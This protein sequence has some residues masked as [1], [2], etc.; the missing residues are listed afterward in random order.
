MT[1]PR[2]V[3]VEDTDMDVTEYFTQGFRQALDKNY[4]KRTVDDR[5][6]SALLTRKASRVTLMFGKRNLPS[7]M[8]PF[9]PYKKPE[10]KTPQQPKSN[11]K[12]EKYDRLKQW[13]AN[14]ERLK[15]LQNKQSRPIFKV[16]HVET[17]I[18][19]PDLTLV[20]S[21]IKG[22]PI[23]K[24]HN[25]FVAPSRYKVP[26][27]MGK[28]KAP[29]PTSKPSNSKIVQSNPPTNKTKKPTNAKI[30]PVTRMA[31]RAS[32]KSTVG[33]PQKAS[34]T[35]STN[36][37][38]K[39]P[40]TAQKKP[41]NSKKTTVKKE[42]PA[43]IKEEVIEENT[44]EQKNKKSVGWGVTPPNEE[45]SGKKYKKTPRAAR[46]QAS[47]EPDIKNEED[48]LIFYKDEEVVLKTPSK[49]RK[50]LLELPKSTPRRSMRLSRSRSGS[51]ALCPVSPET[52]KTYVSP[53]V[54]ISRGKESARKEYTERKSTGGQLKNQPA[55]SPKAG[56]YFFETVLDGEINRIEEM[57]QKWEEYRS[58]NE[59]TEEISSMIDVAINQSKLLISSK[60]QQFRSLLNQ[61]KT[62]KFDFK[63]ITCED[64]HGFWDMVYHQV[65]NV[66]GRFANLD[67]LKANDWEEVRSEKKIVKKKGKGRAK[68]PAAKSMIKDLIKEARKKQ[69]QQNLEQ[70]ELLVKTPVVK[71]LVENIT[72]NRSIL[73][74]RAK[75]T[76]R[77]SVKV[78]FVDEERSSVSKELFSEDKENDSRRMNSNRKS[79]NILTTPLHLRRSTRLNPC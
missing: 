70:D 30:E 69:K 44:L 16:Q 33:V 11:K 43:K 31:T 18:G 41:V 39:T 78:N 28:P 72:P 50:S 6:L 7:N 4:K 74:S 14:K 46:K 61:C 12:Q 15:R 77:K 40:V 48:E 53:F 35:K 29:P 76:G 54:T 79:E 34:S 73:K 26:G 55:T 25:S 37:N 8:S 2:L 49:G 21:E 62:N 17:K 66:N 3:F 52:P 22:K 64:L 32:A 24:V 67:R 19:L 38:T 23:K 57:C 42:N 68:K 10:T 36:K 27:S 58:E 13:K 56:A 60:F 65:E 45:R 5:R 1:S 9:T 20:Y 75:S 59:V 51:C 71:L 47:I 63:K